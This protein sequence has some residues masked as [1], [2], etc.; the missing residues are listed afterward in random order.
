MT[1]SS[2][3]SNAELL[4]AINSLTQAVNNISRTSSSNI[5]QSQNNHSSQRNSVS[6]PGRSGNRHQGGGSKDYSNSSDREFEKYRRVQEGQKKSILQLTAEMS[7][8]NKQLSNLSNLTANSQRSYKDIVDKQSDLFS[9]MTAYGRLSEK[10]Q[11]KLIDQISKAMKS[12]KAMSDFKFQSSDTYGRLNEIKSLNDRLGNALTDLNDFKTKK[13]ASTFGEM[14]EKDIQE[15]IGRI[16]SADVKIKNTTSMQDFSDQY[17]GHT[18]RIAKHQQKID[19]HN[20]KI[21]KEQAIMGQDPTRG[22]KRLDAL[23]KQLEV[24]NNR[25][26]GLKNERASFINNTIEPTI[27]DM[28]SFRGSLN[29]STKSIAR[30]ELAHNAAEK[31][32][33]KLGGSSLTVAGGFG[34]LAKGIKTYYDYM[35]SLMSQGLGGMSGTIAANALKMGASVKELAK[36]YNDFG[37]QVSQIGFESV[38]QIASTGKKAALTLG[39]FGDEALQFANT[40]SKTLI[41]AGFSPKKVKEFGEAQK[42]YT[43]RLQEMQYLT[44]ESI[45][46]LTAFDNELIGNTDTQEMMMR[47]SK[48]ERALKVKELLATKDSL[49]MYIGNNAEG[50]KFMKTLQKMNGMG[51]E[52]RLQNSVELQGLMSMLGYDTASIQKAGELARAQPGQLSKEDKEWQAKILM[53]IGSKSKAI[54]GTGNLAQEQAMQSYMKGTNQMLQELAQEGAN[55]QLVQDLN[56][57]IDPN[58]KEAKAAKEGREPSKAVTSIMDLTNWLGNAASNPMLSS[59]IAIAAG[60]ATI[61]A[62]T[63]IKDGASLLGFLK[64]G[65]G[66]IGGKLAGAG[67]KILG[68]LGS[69]G[70][71]GGKM[72]GSK[73]PVLG[74]GIA[75]MAAYDR[76]ANGDLLGAGGEMLSGIAGQVPGIGTAVSMGIDASLMAR[77]SAKGTGATNLAYEQIMAG[78]K[79]VDVSRTAIN[80]API[81][82]TQAANIVAQNGSTSNINNQQSLNT[83]TSQTS[84]Q[85]KDEV[86]QRLTK[87]L[88]EDSAKTDEMVKVLKQILETNTSSSS[89]LI[90]T[91]KTGAGKVSF[92]DLMDKRSIFA[93]R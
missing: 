82:A 18:N 43:K 37:G 54:Q 49:Q 20:K 93:N 68:G 67:S 59:L 32:I 31:I 69:V 33:R 63:L 79:P 7:K 66:G 40:M 19:D 51:V 48:E 14:N 57:K 53:D 73:L 29:D 85:S 88:E 9:A 25:Q 36:F 47:L 15:V 21:K 6:S 78:V 55:A 24:L 60:T 56:G 34:L 65:V 76:M 46:N 44:G 87:Q 72:L 50:M 8:Y 4:R 41:S 11:N 64:G 3:T 71:L 22:S 92:N 26:E 74:L 52:D 2:T 17:A 81:M 39:L 12:N 89:E 45:A 86:I 28:E 10:N 83:D 90:G 5:R 61:A 23:V 91:L 75:G 13:R 16:Q 35:Q 1:P 84:Q 62:S 42:D 38:N 30:Y 77:D 58:S 70:K 27:S 80:T